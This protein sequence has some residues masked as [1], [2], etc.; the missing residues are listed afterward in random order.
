MVDEVAHLLTYLRGR[1]VPC[2]VCGYNLRDLTRPVC[3][4]CRHDVMLTVGVLRPRLG[5][6]MIAL[7]P[8]A[9]SGIAAALLLVPIVLVTLMGGDPPPWPPL[10]ADA[11][12]WTSTLA[13]LV[14]FRKRYLF[15]RQRAAVQ[16]AW[17]LGLWVVHL[18]AFAGLVT[19]VSLI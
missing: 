3:P 10:V 11:F 16:R 18:A 19:A 12:G 15:L 6:L 2:P 1:D 5:W 14:L 9:F 8:C 7:V 13:G 17:A 4:E